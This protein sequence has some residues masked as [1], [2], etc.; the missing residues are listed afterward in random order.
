M[1]IRGAEVWRRGRADL[2]L[3]NG[4]VAEIGALSPAQGEPMI[5]ARGGALLP[6]LH[7]HHLHLAGL[8]TRA[9]SVMCGQ[10]SLSSCSMI[11]DVPVPWV[12]AARIITLMCS[13]VPF[14]AK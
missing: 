4:H 5:D 13:G 1:L 12:A 14:S 8:A 2:R 6:G 11:P 10:V 9:D 7:D 3:A